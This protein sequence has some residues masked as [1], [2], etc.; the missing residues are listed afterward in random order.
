M[1]SNPEA[2]AA[3]DTAKESKKIRILIGMRSDQN[4]GP[5]FGIV[6]GKILTVGIYAFFVFGFRYNLSLFFFPLHCNYSY[7]FCVYISV[8]W[9]F[10]QFFLS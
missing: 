1:F 4:E 9:D 5:I 8:E 2:V 7:A 6:P 3:G 10:D